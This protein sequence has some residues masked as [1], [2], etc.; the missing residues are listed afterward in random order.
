MKK[1]LFVMN[2]LGKAGAETAMMELL[3]RLSPDEYAIS[4]YVLMGQGEMIGELPEY[5]RLLNTTYK[6][7]SVLSK[8][9][10]PYMRRTVLRAMLT[11]GT[12]IKLIPYLI[13]NVWNM[14]GKRKVLPEKLLWRVLSDGADRMNE[15][16]DLA[17]A[18][19]EGG[20]TYYVADHVN[21]KQ[22]AAFVHVD[23]ERA[24]YTKELDSGCYL[25]YNKI[26]AV[27][28]EV[29]KAFLKVYPE[30]QEKTEVFHNLLN[31]EN[32]RN[33]AEQDGGFTDDFSGMRILSVGRLTEQ[34]AFELSIEAM[35][36]LKERG[37]NVRW[38]ILG[39]GDQRRKLEEQIKKLGLE[40]DF[41]MPGAVSNPYPYM[42]Q[43]DIYV[44]A[45]RFEGKSIAIQEAQILGKPILVS[46]CSGNRE[47]V[48]ADV[49]GLMCQLTPEGI[50]N[51]ILELLHNEEKRKRLAANA[52]KRNEEE[53]SELY[54]LTSMI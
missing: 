12:V 45:S 3:R 40:Q 6:D 18:Y 51:G 35:K 2:T 32:I 22:K 49:D 23:Y 34:K 5:V 4:L 28:D 36:M 9:G 29:R 10:R 52:R 27:S 1:I 20:S 13:K 42:K 39:D 19:L 7:C 37:E 44:H 43:A 17:V 26:F 30:C 46:D 21:A 8:E 53:K 31:C 50:C 38:Y 33:K 14:L 47:Q 25:K 11:R 15:T 41:F 48:I 16:Y 54:K 24:G